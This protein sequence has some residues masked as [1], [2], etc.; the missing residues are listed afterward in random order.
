MR[1]ALFGG[2]FNPIHRGHT[3]LAQKVVQTG[4]VDEV[5]VMP[6]PLNPLKQQRADLLDFEVRLHLC[7]LA[8]AQIP[9]L[10]VCD[11]EGRL[12][13]PSYTW[14]TLSALR[15]QYPAHEFS[16]LIGED[17]WQH[18]DCWREAAAI[19]QSTSLLVYGRQTCGLTLHRPDGSSVLLSRRLPLYPVS[20]TALRAALATADIPFCRQWLNGHVLRYI[21]AHHLYS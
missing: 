9:H 4:V 8:T 17:N 16:L 1:V 13:L 5:W 18:F 11:V 14:R 12:P 6:S 21:L 20:S 2:S 15:E 7:R 10:R 19:R 3:S